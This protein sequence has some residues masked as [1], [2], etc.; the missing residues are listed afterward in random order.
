MSLL[1]FFNE[2]LKYNSNVVCKGC[3]DFSMLASELKNIFIVQIEESNYRC[4]MLGVTKEEAILILKNSDLTEKKIFYKIGLNVDR[5]FFENILFDA[6]KENEKFN[7]CRKITC[8]LC[9]R[10]KEFNA[11]L[12]KKSFSNRIKML[13][14]GFSRKKNHDKTSL[15]LTS[16]IYNQKTLFLSESPCRFKPQTL[17]P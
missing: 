14:V 16:L 6:C 5:L 8:Q 2:N 10:V 11:E 1:V 9:N 13:K 4:Y 12:K 7:Y 15:N 17:N 3:H